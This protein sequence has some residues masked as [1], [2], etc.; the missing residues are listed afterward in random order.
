MVCF[1]YF[2]IP[3]N[4]LSTDLEYKTNGRAVPITI[5]IAA[6]FCRTMAPLFYFSVLS[7]ESLLRQPSADQRRG[8]S[9]YLFCHPTNHNC[10]SLLP[11]NNRAVPISF[12]AIPRIICAAAFYQT[13]AE[14]FLLVLMP[15]PES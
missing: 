12:V 11:N 10:S 1:P 8:C 13:T 2:Q 5:V 3:I 14:L 4:P 7:L 9:Y 6:A 15:S